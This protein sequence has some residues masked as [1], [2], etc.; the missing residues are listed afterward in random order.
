M[1]SWLNLRNKEHIDCEILSGKRLSLQ[2]VIRLYGK[3]RETLEFESVRGF[4]GVNM[5]RF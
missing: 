5:L 4:I 1:L 2:A 3:V